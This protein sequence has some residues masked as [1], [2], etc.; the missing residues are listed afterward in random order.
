MCYIKHK[1]YN[2]SREDI[3]KMAHIGAYCFAEE[4]KGN[5]NT[6][7]TNGIQEAEKLEPEYYTDTVE[8]GQTLSGKAQ[9]WGT[10][11]DEIVKLNN[12]KDPNK[13][14]AGFKFNVPNN[15]KYVKYTFQEGDTGLARAKSSG[16]K[17]DEYSARNSHIK[18][19]N[20]IPVGTWTWELRVLPVVKEKPIPV[21]GTA[22]QSRPV[23]MTPT[24]ATQSTS[25]DQYD[26]VNDPDGRYRSTAKQWKH[27]KKDNVYATPTTV[28]DI[29][30]KNL[31]GGVYSDRYGVFTLNGKP[32]QYQIQKG[33][34]YDSIAKK[35]GTTIDR[36]MLDNKGIDPRRL[37]IGQKILLQKLNKNIS[38]F[39]LGKNID[40]RI[41]MEW[42]GFDQIARQGKGELYLTIG[43]GH[44]HPGVKSGQKISRADAD[45]Y[46]EG[47]MA[48]VVETIQRWNANNKLTPRQYEVLL[49]YGFNAG[50]GN[51]QKVLVNHI[52]KGKMADAIK[53]MSHLDS[54]KNKEGL[55][56]RHSWRQ[57]HWGAQ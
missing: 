45:K 31:I 28:N 54:Y 56:H 50:V 22:V 11:V 10:T 19:W 2:F 3:L 24:K 5:V 6:G 40:H 21:P 36:L 15:S 35:Y 27:R 29:D 26:E 13:I 48:K 39:S 46:Y 49:D 43:Y 52:N 34:T 20:K 23:P 4:N 25:N 18:D 7:Q 12:I 17:W 47:D 8:K 30:A 57:A 16:M 14:P 32:V 42:E 37:K 53:A 1:R 33:D 51:L 38:K 9:E 55:K 44:H 41:A